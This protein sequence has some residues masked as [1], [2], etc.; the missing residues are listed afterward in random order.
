MKCKYCDNEQMDLV[1]VYDDPQ[2]KP[3]I[4]YNLYQC[5]DCGAICKNQVWEFKGD[6]WMDRTN[7]E[8]QNDL[9]KQCN[10]KKD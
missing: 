6:Y 3:L 9:Q 8:E 4:A 5:A 10:C 7:Q 1:A 2:T